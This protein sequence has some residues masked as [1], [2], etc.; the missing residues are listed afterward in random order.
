MQSPQKVCQMSHPE[1]KPSMSLAR[2]FWKS[3]FRAAVVPLLVIELSFLLVYWI[4]AE[5]T[6]DRNVAAVEAVSKDELGRSARSQAATIAQTLEGVSGLTRTFAAETGRVLAGPVPDVPAAERARYVRRD[7]GMLVTRPGTTQ[8]AAFFSGAVPVGPAQMETVWRSTLLD[9]LMEAITTASPLIAQTYVNTHESYNRIYPGFDVVATYEPGMVIPDFNF[10]YEADAA[11]NPGRKAVW[12]DAYVDPAGGGWMVSSIAPVYQGDHLEAVVG[13]DVTIKTIIDQILNLTL[14]WDGY[15]LLVGR[16][17]TILALPKRGEADFGL[18]ELTDY[19]YADVIHGDTF[20]PADF[21]VRQRP[22]TAVLAAAIAAGDGE[23][24]QVDLGRSLIGSVAP[25]GGPGWSLVVLTPEAS[26]LANANDLHAEL[27]T[28][29]TGMIVIL[30]VFYIG[31]FAFL[32]VRS[33]AMSHRVAA[34]LRELE[35]AI[36]RIGKGDYDQP[37]PQ[38]DV[39][40]LNRLGEGLRHMAEHLGQADRVRTQAERQVQESLD[41]E[42]ALNEKQRQFIDVVSHEFRTPLAIIDSSARAFERRADTM[43]PADVRERAGRMRVAVRRLCDV[44]DSGLAFSRAEKAR[45]GDCQPFDLA[46][47][48]RGVIEEQREAFPEHGIFLEAAPLP[49]VTGNVGA[50]RVA[51]AALVNNAARYSS[52]GSDVRVDLAGDDRTVTITVVDSGPG[53]EPE[54]LPRVREEFYRG[55]NSHGTHGA[56]VG[57]YVADVCARLHG[58]TLAVDSG[59]GGQGTRCVLRLPLNAIYASAG[60]EPDDRRECA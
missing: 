60:D 8:A 31:F 57:L 7:D 34:P 35:G 2:W 1:T 28:V 19:T 3:Y 24:F 17:G 29:G 44:V 46:E 33:R 22:D 6:Y 47:V 15:A 21:N 26:I 23:V 25:V 53:I 42:R 40:E 38:T 16:D 18:S 48:V 39:T 30:L 51:I 43:T 27:K 56:G 59:A 20:K 50:I 13:I 37:V 11:H 58:G 45:V 49:V 54:D 52:E 36:E 55:G 10:Y 12:T 41:R 9:P 4:S 5:T 32:Y 14:P